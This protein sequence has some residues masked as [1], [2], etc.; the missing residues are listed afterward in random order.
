M[1]GF[2]RHRLDFMNIFALTSCLF[3]SIASLLTLRGRDLHLCLRLRRDYFLLCLLGLYVQNHLLNGLRTLYQ[4]ERVFPVSS[5]VILKHRIDYLLVP[6]FDINR[7]SQELLQ[8]STL[9]T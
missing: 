2:N 3:G 7:V 8:F 6:Q 5:L 1:W 4:I 9:G